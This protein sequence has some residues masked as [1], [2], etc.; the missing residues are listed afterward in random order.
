MEKMGK[1]Q[2]QKPRRME[3]DADIEVTTLKIP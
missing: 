1:E 2:G 3:V